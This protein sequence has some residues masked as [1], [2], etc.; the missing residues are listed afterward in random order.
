MKRVALT[1]FLLLVLGSPMLLAQFQIG[2]YLIAKAGVNAAKIP[3]GSKTGVTFNGIP[4]FGAT[5]VMPF[6]K[7]N[8]NMGVGVDL[9]VTRY[10]FLTRPNSGANE[11][12]RFTSQYSYFSLAPYVVLSGF[13]VGLNVS[14]LSLD[15]CVT[16]ES[17]TIDNSIDSDNIN[18][19]IFEL[20]IGGII[21]VVD[22]KSGRLNVNITGGYNLNGFR[23]GDDSEF[24]PQGASL[25]LGFSY[26]FK[27]K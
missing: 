27:L 24:N 19:P 17:G 11:D 13:V 12:N 3:S 4:D 7:R 22:E 25:G 21:P 5:F 10:S 18:A 23:D 2:P 1:C 15:G 9:G 26:F 20:R 6:S 16:N 8:E 14:L